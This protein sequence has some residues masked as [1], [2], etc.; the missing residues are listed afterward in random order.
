VI[1]LSLLLL[2]CSG[3]IVDPVGAVKAMVSQIAAHPVF[4]QWEY[5][6]AVINDGLWWTMATLPGINLEDKLNN[7]LDTFINTPGSVAYNILHNVAMAFDVQVGD[8][9]GL[10]PIV[11]LSRIEYYANNSSHYNQSLIDANVC[12]GVANDYVM[13]FP[14]ILPDGTFCRSK[15]LWSD[16]QYM[17]MA[18][19]ARL[20]ARYNR[21]EYLDRV[22]MMQLT[23]AERLID[24]KTNLSWHGFNT[25]ANQSS[26]CKWSRANGWGMI[27]HMEVM[28]ALQTATP[29]SRYYQPVLELLQ[30]HARG[31]I[32]VQSEDGRWRQLLDVPS[33]FL[34]TSTTGMFL[35][36]FITGVENGWLPKEEFDPVIRKAWNGLSSTIQS[37][38]TVTGICQGTGIGPNITFYENRGTQ[39]MDSGPGL[40]S[41]LHAAL[42]M[43]RYITKFGN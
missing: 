15:V 26:C 24:P 41:V 25:T 2:R 3:G 7:V 4:F 17:G 12:F 14:D 9:I 42:A 21:T 31:V 34:E 19:L 5:G 28:K 29:R 27:S 1:V 39:Y 18:L 30:K 10:F 6:S 35:W 38:G 13:K 36:T 37:D 43:V 23:F 16:D 33:T 22:G 32:K 11:Y 20:A 40:G 8:H